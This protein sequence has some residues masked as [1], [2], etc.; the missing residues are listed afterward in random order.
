MKTRTFQDVLK[1]LCAHRGRAFSTEYAE[2]RPDLAQFVNDRLRHA[3]HFAW[4]RDL[5]VYEQ[6]RYRPAYNPETVYPKG[7]EVYK[8]NDSGETVYYRSMVD[9]NTGN[10]P[11]TDDGMHWKTVDEITDDDVAGYVFEPRIAT[12]PTAQ[13]SDGGSAI[14]EKVWCVCD[15]DPRLPAGSGNTHEFILTANN[16]HV[17]ESA[18]PAAP[19][20]VFLPPV[21][22]FTTAAWEAPNS[23]GDIVYFDESKECWLSLADENNDTP[24]AASANWRKIGFP[25]VLFDYVTRTACCDFIRA[26]GISGQDAESKRRAVNDLEETAEER[27]AEDALLHAEQ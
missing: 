16:L 18:Y 19:W 27:M 26:D 15:A 5:L 25:A 3:W 10:D 8:L 1:A 24:E 20:V 4:W 14:G 12:D 21:P 7:R 17:R 13:D 2:S 9:D 6:R 23:A 11:D 22:V